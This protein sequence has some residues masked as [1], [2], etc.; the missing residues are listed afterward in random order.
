[1]IVTR[2]VKK[3]SRMVMKVTKKV[4]IDFHKDNKDCQ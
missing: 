1:M 2:M 3:I 4:K